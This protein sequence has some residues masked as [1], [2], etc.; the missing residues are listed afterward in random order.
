M[1]LQQAIDSI[2]PVDTSLSTGAWK[3]LANLTKPTG[4]ALVHSQSG[5][6]SPW[7]LARYEKEPTEKDEAEEAA[8]DATDEAEDKAEDAREEASE[9][10]TA[11]ATN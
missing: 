2:V 11:P 10:P 4:G 8:E 7:T 3:H 9:A 6:S 1:Q 5:E